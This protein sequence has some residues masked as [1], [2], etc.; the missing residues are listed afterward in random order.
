MKYFNYILTVVLINVF[1]VQ[2]IFA[3]SSNPFEIKSRLKYEIKEDIEMVKSDSFDN[4][5]ESN[6]NIQFDSLT[7]EIDTTSKVIC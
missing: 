1:F 2:S 3:Q 6:D 4:L 5:S 7:D